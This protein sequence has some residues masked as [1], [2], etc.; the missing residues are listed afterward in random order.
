MIQLTNATLATNCELYD[1]LKLQIENLKYGIDCCEQ[2]ESKAELAYKT[3][4]LKNNYSD[5][6]INTN[7][8]CLLTS[9]QQYEMT[10]QPCTGLVEIIDYCAIS[11]TYDVTCLN[12]EAIL[13]STST[14]LGTVV[15]DTLE[16]SF[17]NTTWTTYAAPVPLGDDCNS[18]TA[19]P[20]T[21]PLNT[22]TGSMSVQIPENAGFI[23]FTHTLTTQTSNAIKTYYDDSL[24]TDIVTLTFTADSGDIYTVS[25]YKYKMTL[26]VTDQLLQVGYDTSDTLNP[27]RDFCRTAHDSLTASNALNEAL[28]PNFILSLPVTQIVMDRESRVLPTTTLYS[29]RVVKVAEQDCSEH[30]ST[31]VHT[32]GPDI[33]SSLMLCDE[34]LINPTPTSD[35]I[36][37]GKEVSLRFYAQASGGTIINT[38]TPVLDSTSYS[39]ETFYTATVTPG[40]Y[41]FEHIRACSQVDLIFLEV[42]EKFD[43][44]VSALT[45][46]VCPTGDFTLDLEFEGGVA[47]FT[48]TYTVDTV[49]TKTA[50]LNDD[51]S[52]VE[53]FTVD[54]PVEIQSVTDAQGKVANITGQTLYNVS[55]APTDTSAISSTAV[56]Y[57]SDGKLEWQTTSTINT[58]YAT[59]PI[60]G[61]DSFKLEILDTSSNL[62]AEATF[63]FTYTMQSPTTP[64]LNWGLYGPLFTDNSFVLDT[65]TNS[66]TV[67]IEFDKLEWAILT[68]TVGVNGGVD[69][70]F[71]YTYTSTDICVAE[72]MST[73]ILNTY[74]APLYFKLGGGTFNYRNAT[75]IGG[76]SLYSAA[77]FDYGVSGIGSQNLSAN[78]V[79]DQASWVIGNDFVANGNACTVGTPPSTVA[80]YT[81]VTYNYNQP[82]SYDF[83]NGPGSVSPTTYTEPQ[84]LAS[85][86]VYRALYNTVFR[87]PNTSRLF[88]TEAGGQA[89]NQEIT[90]GS[91]AAPITVSFGG[92]LAALPSLS[93]NL[94]Y[95]MAATNRVLLPRISLTQ[96][97]ANGTLTLTAFLTTG[98]ADGGEH[99]Y[100]IIAG[101]DATNPISYNYARVKVQTAPGAG[102]TTQD[103]ASAPVTYSTNTNIIGGVNP[104][105]GLN[106]ISETVTSV[107]TTDGIYNVIVEA[108]VNLSDGNTYTVENNSQILVVTF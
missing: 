51:G 45:E 86:G 38:G 14:P 47:P 62:L 66:Y 36:V 49:F 25:N 42:V 64:T 100:A 3:Q 105:S 90:M 6:P 11:A 98:T 58:A 7:N 32:F 43:V 107:I 81:P 44:K 41:T 69:L 87:S 85:D 103:F 96:M 23:T 73:N 48:I 75:C 20:A 63:M 106:S 37:A 15:S 61:T 71:R 104:P 70:M 40:L 31:Q 53:Q 89:H 68:G 102:Y 30:T 29:R 60:T 16:Y 12:S 33:C 76:T 19:L 67:D 50:T 88:N 2:Y 82:F 93:G 59:L 78:A 18:N 108:S 101:Q 27:Y 99:P 80:S 74:K 28:W 72:S 84:F 39:Q 13:T 1:N 65:L 57:N 83:V 77:Y 9:A 26:T 22:N 35:V 4:F 21:F 95:Y 34:P 24:S 54:T 52:I 8:Y 94:K 46:S 10:E 56:V 91:Q 97:Q 79:I 55:I 5:C 92:T 17:D